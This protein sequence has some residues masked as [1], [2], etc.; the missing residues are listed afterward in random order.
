MKPLKNRFYQA[1]ITCFQ[2]GQLLTIEFFKI[3][4][5]NPFK[6]C[7]RFQPGQIVNITS[8]IKL[9]F[10]LFFI[11]SLL[12]EEYSYHPSLL[13]TQ[14]DILTNGDLLCKW[15]CPLQKHDFLFSDFSC[16]CCFSKL[17]GFKQSLYERDIFW[18]DILLLFTGQ[19]DMLLRV[20]DE[21][22]DHLSK[23]GDFQ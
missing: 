12:N 23:L 20:R 15:R 5:K 3:K 10:K 7:I 6:Y 22:L 17:I 14:C 2:S 18:G 19:G 21:Q 16:V 4:F 11:F 9:I 1:L 13:G 8:S